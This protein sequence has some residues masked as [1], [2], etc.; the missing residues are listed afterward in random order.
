MDAEFWKKVYKY[1][2]LPPIWLTFIIVPA[3]FGLLIYVAVVG[4]GEHFL[5]YTSYFL[6]AYSLALVSVRVPDIIRFFK[7]I[8]N[9]NK[10][11]V[12][13]RT[14]T[15]L[16]VKLTLMMHLSIN[17]AYAIFQLWLAVYHTSAWYYSMAAYYLLLTLMR[18]LILRDVRGRTGTD[19]VRE[20][21]MYRISG[22]CLC[23]MNVVLGG[24][25]MF[26]TQ[27]GHGARHH[28]ITTIALAAFTFTS[29]TLAIIDNIKYRKYGSPLYSA[30]K[31]ISLVSA[32][33][34]LL[35]LETAMLFAFG[36][37]D[38]GFNKIMTTATGAAVCVFVIAV[39][40]YMIVR[41]TLELNKLKRQ[42]CTEK[43]EAGT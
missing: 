43:T 22:I 12:K 29:V 23:F 39:A 18:Y 8:K 38:A 19:M 24:I 31:A 6:S 28:Y 1:L 35:T 37:A 26:I 27:F 15:E 20:Y 3:S 25:V 36:E 7:Y 13:F 14:D 16:R 5:A 9:E 11:V 30:A 2:L 10:Y 40:I 17:A 32:A 42:K 41:S 33:F 34:S 21:K 4:L